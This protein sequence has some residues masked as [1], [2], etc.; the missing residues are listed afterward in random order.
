MRPGTRRR[1][2]LFAIGV[3]AS[4][5]AGTMYG[6]VAA[7]IWLHAPVT[8]AVVGL[9]HGFAISAPIAAV[10]IFAARSRIG[11]MLDQAPFLVTV[12]VKGLLYGT[13]ITLVVLGELGVHRVQVQRYAAAP[14][15]NPFAPLSVAVSFL[16]AFI[17]IFVLEMSRIVGGRTL[18]DIVLGRYHRP[19][20]EERFFLFVDIA[21]STPLAERIGPPAVNRFLDRVFRIS[22]DPIDDHRGEIY[23][24]VGDEMVI[25][26]P[27]ER[28]RPRSLPVACFFAIERA[29]AAAA[30]AFERDFGAAPRVRGALHA[31]PVVSGEVGESRRA[32]VFHGDVVNTTA[33]LEQATR[34]L[35][36]RFLVSADALDRLALDGGYALEDLGPQRLRGRDAPVRVFAVDGAAG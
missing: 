22:S 3:L 14:F 4:M 29:L 36:R 23:Q 8:G 1:L 12:A 2:G 28:G 15:D 6:A 35:G 24:Y 27:L 20:S 26:W 13:I 18:R 19:R 25:T 32:I 33:R 34:D 17:F 31:G 16:M 9:I 11:R 21:G 30:P 10:E 5:L 7:Y